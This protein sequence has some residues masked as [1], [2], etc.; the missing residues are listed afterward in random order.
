MYRKRLTRR[1]KLQR[2]YIQSHDEEQS[3]KNQYAGRDSEQEEAINQTEEERNNEESDE[4]SYA[5]LQSLRESTRGKW[6]R[7]TKRN[8][9][10]DQEQTK[11]NTPRFKVH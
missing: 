1:C 7:S 5:F 3:T 8:V 11:E 4:P 2:I 9:L 6:D 10:N